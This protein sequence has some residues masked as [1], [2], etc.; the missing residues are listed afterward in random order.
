MTKQYRKN[1]I[2]RFDCKLDEYEYEAIK[3]YCDEN[4]ITKREFLTRAMEILINEYKR[5][6]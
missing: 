6:I 1:P 3:D 5:T 2:R 4:N